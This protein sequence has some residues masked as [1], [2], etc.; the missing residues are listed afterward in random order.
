MYKAVLAGIFAFVICASAATA[1]EQ[2]SRGGVVLT[3]GKIAYIKSALRLTPE[4]EQYWP[5]VEAALHGLAH[6]GRHGVKSADTTSSVT[7]D[8]SGVQRLAAAAMP[9][10]MSLREEQRRK[11]AALVRSLGLGSLAAAF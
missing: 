6:A 4:Q 7:L 1:E 5:P 9:L 11:V 2:A 8:Q 3:H 10:F